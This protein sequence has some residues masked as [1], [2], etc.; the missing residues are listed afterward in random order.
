MQKLVYLSNSRDYTRQDDINE[1][2]YFTRINKL[3]DEGWKVAHMTHD[4]V[5][6]N[7][8]QDSLHKESLVALVLLEKED[9]ESK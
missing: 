8:S 6:V 4:V 7:Y 9:E 1:N 5:E 3:L 2:N